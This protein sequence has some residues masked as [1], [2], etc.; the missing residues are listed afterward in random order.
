[1][2]SGS[3]PAVAAA[4]EARA[5]TRRLVARVEAGAFGEIRHILHIGIG[6]SALGPALL[7]DAVDGGR[8]RYDTHVISN[9]DGVALERAMRACDPARTLVVVVSKTF[10]T[11]E[12]MTNAERARDWIGGTARFVAVTAAPERAADW[13]V[14]PENVLGFAESVGGRYSLWSAVGVTA[15]LSLGWAAFEALLAGGHAMDAHFE[16]AP[17]TENA[18]VLAAMV[19]VLYAVFLGAETRAVFA[20]DERLRL[21]PSF[22]QQLEMESNGKRVDRD[23]KVLTHPSAA[24]TW[25]GTGTDAQHAVFQLL[26]QGTHLVPCEF[27]MVKTP[28][29]GLGAAHHRQLLANAVAQGAALMRGRSEAEALAMSGGDAALAAAKTF[30]GNRPSIAIVLDTLDPHTLGALIAFYEHRT[31]TAAMLLGINP[32][33][34]WG[35]ELG[36]DMARAAL[37]RGAGEGFDASSRALLARLL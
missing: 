19:D 18:P 9:I 5:A 27:V 10:T 21:L 26:H 23:G 1:R 3:G 24:I 7:V 36:K 17:V 16:S 29:H 31:F 6:G 2:G 30:P 20:Y 37:D 25:G 15:A 8:G 32:F 28:G 11:V 14:A 12:T 4:A 13:G 35:V 34:Q 22:L 33:D